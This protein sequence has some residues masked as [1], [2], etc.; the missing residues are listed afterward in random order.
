VTTPGIPAGWL[1][2]SVDR[3][4]LDTLAP[5]TLTLTVLPNTLPPGTW[6][7]TVV[8]RGTNTLFLSYA[9]DVTLVVTAPAGPTISNITS[10]V[11]RVNDAST[12]TL[13]GPVASS[14]R[15]E[16]DWTD[17]DG[18]GPRDLREASMPLD[19][20]F[21][22]NGNSG[23]IA[24][25]YTYRSSLT[26]DGRSG[27]ATTTQCYYFGSYSSVVVTMSIVDQG[28]LRG[29]NAQVSITRPPGSN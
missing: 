21:Q 13:P 29:P 1:Q 2:A 14:F 5:A 27:H 3:L 9:M 15:V 20:T 18:N 28:G 25:P 8:L 17:P 11:I 24:A 7:A 26:G 22:P 16:F 19:Y 12:C 6:T 23:S 10:S 4:T